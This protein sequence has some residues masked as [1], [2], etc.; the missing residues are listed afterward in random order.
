MFVT[1][2]QRWSL[3]LFHVEILVPILGQQSS[4][5]SAHFLQKVA[6]PY[7][8]PQNAFQRQGEIGIVY[9]NTL[10]YLQLWQAS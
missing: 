2:I 5:V 1:H 3:S 4:D 10:N 7:E 8:S 6:H 9:S